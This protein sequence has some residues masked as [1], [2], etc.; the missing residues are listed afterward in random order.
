[1]RKYSRTWKKPQIYKDIELAEDNIDFKEK[2]IITNLF[3]P[4]GA[5]IEAL[6]SLERSREEGFDKALVVAATGI[7]KTYLAAFDSIKAKRIL[8]VAHREEIINQAAQSFKNVRNS[9]EAY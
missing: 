6:Y 8:F 9:D 7:G 3:T 1:M 2:D 4:R 5:Q